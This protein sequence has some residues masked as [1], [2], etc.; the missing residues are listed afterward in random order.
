MLRCGIVKNCKPR[1]SHSSDGFCMADN[2]RSLP[3]IGN[4]YS[5]VLTVEQTCFFSAFCIE[6]SHAA[7]SGKTA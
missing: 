4:T 3:L 2:K 6:G 7:Y 5:F 1:F